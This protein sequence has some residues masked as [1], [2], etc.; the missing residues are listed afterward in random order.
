MMVLVA[1]APAS[2]F[3]A[4]DDLGRTIKLDKEPERIISLA[5]S[6]TEILFT[7]GAGER[8][9]GVTDFCNYPPEARQRRSVGGMINPSIERI[10]ALGPDLVILT[11]EGNLSGT[12]RKLESL[13]VPTF[14]IVQKG[15]GI[16]GIF[17]SVYAVGRAV[18]A[19]PEAKRKVKETRRAIRAIERRVERFEKIRT[20]FLLW[21][22]PFISVGGDTF[23]HEALESAGGENAVS[24]LSGYPKLGLEQVASLRP[25][26]IILAVGEGHGTSESAIRRLKGVPALDSG[27]VYSIDADI[28]A[29]PTPRLIVGLARMAELLHPEAF[30]SD[31]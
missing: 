5:P 29:R 17:E 15:K 18:G 1:P 3:E 10:V 26:A 2:S 8:V 25:D 14:G 22:D 24:A 28:V 21:T 31:E 12:V 9:I 4:R 11:S 13:G 20:L 7:L 23:V 30:R 16:E 27:R 6:V 19:L